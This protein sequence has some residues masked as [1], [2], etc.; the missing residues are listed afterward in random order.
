MRLN[1]NYIEEKA[2]EILRKN[3]L[4]EPGF[5]I[6][7][8]AKKLGIILKSEDL[9]DDVS[10]FFVMTED[11]V[12]VITYKKGEVDNRFRFTVAHEIGHYT[13]HAKEQPVFV[14]RKPVMLF[15]N[16]ASSTGEV[17]KEREANAFAAALLMPKTLIVQE[18]NSAPDYIDEAITYLAKRFGVSEQAM[19]FR[20]SNLGYGIG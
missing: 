7:K 17:L 9:G 11:G 12:P 10:G 2:E 16:T 5:D 15:R 8:L 13:L 3:N 1:F 20:L 6:K 4:F 14:D 19:S 18:I